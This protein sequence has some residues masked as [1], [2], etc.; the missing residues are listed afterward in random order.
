MKNSNPDLERLKVILRNNQ[1]RAMRAIVS[2]L[3]VPGDGEP[4][5]DIER[6]M[7]SLFAEFETP[8]VPE[9]GS[10]SLVRNQLA[11]TITDI[12]RQAALQLFERL[13]GKVEQPIVGKDGGPIEY[14]DRTELQQELARKIQAAADGAEA[15]DA[16]I[17][18]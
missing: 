14:I 6:L 4:Q 9:K 12:Q 2:V 17:T 16:R 8:E 1:E 3:Y 11:R 18:H 7:Q 10:A 15:E 13:L 5:N